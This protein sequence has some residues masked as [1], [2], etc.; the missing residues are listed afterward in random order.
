MS[1]VGDIPF[2][3]PAQTQDKADLLKSLNGYKME[4][5]NN[6]RSGLNPRDDKW[7]MNLDMYWN[8]YDFSDKADW[9][10]QN[11]MPEVPGFVDR[12]AAAMKDAMV[13]TPNGFYN[14]TDPYD[15]EQDICNSIKAMTDVWLSTAGRNQVGQLLDFSSFFEEQM[16]MG[17]MMNCSGVVLWKKDVPGGR[18]AVESV[19]PRFVWLDHTYR[20]LY[21]IRRTEVDAIEIA[22]MGKSTSSRGKPIYNTDEMSRLVGSLVMDQQRKKELTG[23]GQEVSSERK[24][25]ILDEYIASVMDDKG[26]ITMDNEVVVVANDGYIIRG[27]EK[28]P[29]WHGKDW[30]VYTSMM[31][32]PLSPYGRT[33]MED[34]ASLA[35]VF[36]DLTNL[37]LDATYMSSMNAYAMVPSMLKDPTQ[38]NS[39]VWPNKIFQL[40]EGMTAKDF[41]SNIELGTLNEGAINIWQSIKGE[42]STAAG[43]NEISM[44]QIPDKTHISANATA[45]AQQSASSMLRSIAQT[46]ETRFLDPMLD[47]IWKTGLQ[48]VKQSDSRMYEAMGDM[49]PALIGQ[50]RELIKRPITFQARGISQLIQK[51]Q[52]LSALLN[53]MQVLNQNP[54]LMQA[55]AQRLDMNKFIDL[56]FQLSNV[57]ISKIEIS[58]RQ[59]MINNI[60][61][62]FQQAAAGG[63]GGSPTGV[64]NMAGA[65]TQGMGMQKQ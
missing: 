55:F 49:G 5:T 8:R 17:A 33:Y 27:P 18:V 59:Q 11:V 52:Q 47:L 43:M 42:L 54:Q 29:F 20:D 19:D 13:S 39:G 61:Q 40:E 24:P 36:N 41:M 14:V 26:N 31:P 37:I 65:M 34:F 21:R 12:F 53:L 58:A 48:N 50:R 51:Q 63:P 1:V 56:L 60:T 7:R 35:K 62:P 10:S 6:R 32:V 46:V 15:T 28:N 38:V 2:T 30:L 3:I 64:Q 44:G 23:I 22:R 45:G 9:Q 16:K 4:A 57:D 25:I